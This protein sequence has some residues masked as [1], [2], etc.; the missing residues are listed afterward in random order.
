MVPVGKDN[1]APLGLQTTGRRLQQAD[2]TQTEV[3]VAQRS[4]PFADALRKVTDH[5]L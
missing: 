5:L 3:S 1:T 2:D 4:L